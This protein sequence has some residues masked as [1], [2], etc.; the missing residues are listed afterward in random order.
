MQIMPVYYTSQDIKPVEIIIR[1]MQKTI[2]IIENIQISVR[3]Y[4]S[5]N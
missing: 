5:E 3:L 4:Y 2:N 1:I